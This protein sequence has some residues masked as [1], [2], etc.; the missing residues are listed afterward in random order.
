MTT[1]KQKIEMMG[2]FKNMR[3]ETQEK[4][5]KSREIEEKVARQLKK[6]GVKEDEHK[7]SLAKAH[8]VFE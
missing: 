1:L 3:E 6:L 7:I 8:L 4:I 5:K 2:T